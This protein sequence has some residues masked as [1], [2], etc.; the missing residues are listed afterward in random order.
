MDAFNRLTYHADA[1]GKYHP[2]LFYSDTIFPDAVLSPKTVWID[3][4]EPDKYKVTNYDWHTS[5][6][7]LNTATLFHETIHYL[8]DLA[9]G[10]GC[11][12][13]FATRDFLHHMSGLFRKLQ[14]NKLKLPLAKWASQ[15]LDI[16]LKSRLTDFLTTV[17]SHPRF[18]ESILSSTEY[19]INPNFR[20]FSSLCGYER[21]QRGAYYSLGT[22]EII[23]GMAFLLTKKNVEKTLLN[24]KLIDRSDLL[25]VVDYSSYG[26]LYRAAINAFEVGLFSEIDPNQLTREFVDNLFLLIADHALLMPPPSQDVMDK[27]QAGKIDSSVFNPLSR[28]TAACGSIDKQLITKHLHDESFEWVYFWLDEISKKEGWLPTREI[29]ELWINYLQYL[30][31]KTP[32][33]VTIAWQVEG[34]KIRL[35]EPDF[36]LGWY[37]GPDEHKSIYDAIRQIG[38]PMFYRTSSGNQWRYFPKSTDA[39]EFQNGLTLKDKLVQ[40]FMQR[41][42]TMIVAD[43]LLH[44][45]EM[46][47]PIYGWICECDGRDSAPSNDVFLKYLKERPCIAKKIV[48]GWLSAPIESI[49]NYFE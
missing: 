45:S 9:T 38:A 13:C 41:S 6:D 19:M 36:V 20:H 14:V 39:D 24:M 31:Q 16:S 32:A 8:Q 25:E 37:G 46:T 1:L 7:I 35:K 4:I 42:I 34:M 15:E 18:I 2:S 12:Y 5:L 47:C 3:I 11:I 48:E 28:F 27:L 49:F 44:G 10:F 26:D 23:E 29:T 17:H 40:I 22:M 43:H 30:Y 33:D 21:I